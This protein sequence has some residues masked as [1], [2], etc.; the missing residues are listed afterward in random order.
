MSNTNK[1]NAFGNITIPVLQEHKLVSFLKKHRF[2]ILVSVVLISFA[3]IAV[4]PTQPS[5]LKSQMNVSR[6]N[7]VTVPTTDSTS[8]PVVVSD[9]ME[10]DITIDETSSG[11]LL[12]SDSTD[13]ET[14][15]EQPNIPVV[16]DDTILVPSVDSTLEKNTE[17]TH[18]VA[19]TV[20]VDNRDVEN[21]TLSDATTVVEETDLKTAAPIASVEE[22]AKTGPGLYL[23]F[24][25][26][27]GLSLG[28]FKKI[29]SVSK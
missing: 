24:I 7:V 3:A 16:Q 18:T 2:L 17:P 10:A 8:I 23:A 13:E 22:N 14:R 15:E 6:N 28:L 11:T 29:E 19:T 9:D 27:I 5:V 1:K 20:D 4:I 21:S 25:L 12:V 26:A